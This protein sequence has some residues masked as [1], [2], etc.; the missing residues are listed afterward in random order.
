MT[1]SSLVRGVGVTLALLVA[2]TA[3][4]L[5][6]AAWP[7]WRTPDSGRTSFPPRLGRVERLKLMAHNIRWCREQPRC[8]ERV[9][10]TI[11]TEQP[12]VV[13]LATVRGES[14]WSKVGNQVDYLA[15]A[16]GMHAWAFGENFRRGVPFFRQQSGNAVLSKFP[17]RALETQP[18]AGAAPFWRGLLTADY[19]TRRALWA[20]IEIGGRPFLVVSLHNDSYD[21]E[22]NLAQIRQVLGRSGGRPTLLGGD[23]NAVRGSAPIEALRASGRFS[24][25]FDGPPT[26]P[27]S[28]PEQCLDYVLAPRG[29]RLVEHRVLG[30]QVSA[31]LPVVST[32]ELPCSDCQSPIWPGSTGLS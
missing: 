24:G 29:W 27:A 4:L 6:H 14:A 17:L 5:A 7:S 28:R 22:T 15:R 18:L 2:A 31:H 10:A 1:G 16:T 3:V 23:L 13:F 8:L 9:A 32:F 12:D 11:V 30:L 26:Y 25:E 20:E 21:I 19:Q